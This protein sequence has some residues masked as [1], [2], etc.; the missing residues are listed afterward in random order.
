MPSIPKSAE[1]IFVD[2]FRQIIQTNLSDPEL[3]VDRISNEMALSKAQ[4]YRKI[5]ALTGTSPTD[6]LREARLKRA[7]RYL[8]TTD[9]NIAEIAYEVGF[10]SPSYFTK[11]YREYFGHTPNKRQS[12]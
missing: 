4:L 12:I 2:K 11:C 5:K 3:N 8:Q 9:K 1:T 7:D 10:S 6:I